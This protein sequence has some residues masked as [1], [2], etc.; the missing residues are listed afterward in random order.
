M[1]DPAPPKQKMSKTKKIGIIIGVVIGVAI[2]G[3]LVIALANVALYSASSAGNNQPPPT[4]TISGSVTTTG[5]QTH[6]VGIAFYDQSTGENRNSVVGGTHY[7]VDVPNGMH[8]W[9][10]VVAWEGIGG[11]N[12]TCDAG[13]VQYQNTYN[14]FM[15]RDVS[16]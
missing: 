4:V 1:A 3:I 2:A 15:T 9:R 7:Q 12:G 5:F 10:V 14:R 8:N 13:F 16:C 11:S 6:P